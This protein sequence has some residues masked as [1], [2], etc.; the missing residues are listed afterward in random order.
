MSCPR[1]AKVC[2]R[3]NHFDYKKY[4]FFIYVYLDPWTPVDKKY[5][6][7]GDEI[8]FKYQPWYLGKGANGP[9]FRHNQHLA[10]YLKGRELVK[11]PE[12]QHMFDYISKQIEQNRNPNLPSTWDEYKFFWIVILRQ[13][14]TERENR[15]WEREAI[16]VIGR[17]IH[18]GPL[19]NVQS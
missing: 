6:I 18:S 11:S 7:N 3:I 2:P 16:K 10:D 4:N 9:M 1:L 8:E 14:K 13:F 19:V 5:L 15:D 12:K 17:N